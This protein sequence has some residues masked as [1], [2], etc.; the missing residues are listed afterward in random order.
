MQW[1]F[2]VGARVVSNE[3]YN[4]PHVGINGANGQ[5]NRFELNYLH[6]L[7]RGS[8]DAAA[9]YAGRHWADRG[10]TV[11][12][13]RFARIYQTEDIAETRSSVFGIYLVNLYG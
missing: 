9:F 2:V 10:N 13:C 12:G 4:G 7:G 6:D 3:I 11:V 8:S 5:H 1:N